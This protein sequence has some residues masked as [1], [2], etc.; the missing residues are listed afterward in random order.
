MGTG[1]GHRG[2]PNAEVEEEELRAMRRALQSSRWE[3]PERLGQYRGRF[4]SRRKV[5]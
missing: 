3:T 1:G 5:G 4:S 2:Q